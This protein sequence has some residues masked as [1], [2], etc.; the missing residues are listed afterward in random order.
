MT[1]R[2]KV[3]FLYLG[4]IAA[5]AL[6]TTEAYSQRGGGGRSG[7]HAAPSAP[8]PGNAG[9]AM[10]RPSGGAPKAHGNAGAP[11]I[12][13]PGGGAPNISKPN[14]TNPGGGAS[15]PNIGA[16]GGKP[17]GGFER[18][19]A[20]N[21]TPPKL[22]GDGPRGPG[23]TDPPKVG[24]ERP[25][26]PGKTDRPNVAARP[27]GGPSSSQ[28]NDF[29]GGGSQGVDRPDLG[30]QGRPNLGNDNFPKVGDR[31]N[32]STNINVGNVNVGNSVDYSKNQKAW[33]DNHHATGNQVRVNA[34]NRYAGAYNNGAY[35]RGAVGGYPYYGGWG[36]RGA[37]YGWRPVT[38]AS[39]G[40]FMGTAWVSAQPRYYA[41]GTGGNVYYENNIVYV[42]GQ[43]AGTPEE[44]AAQSTALVASAPAQ[45]TD[46]EWLP[47]G[48]FALTRE[49]VNDSQAMLELAVNKQGVVAGTYYNEATQVSR[50]L[51]GMLDKASQRAAIG[52]ADGK[53]T[54]VVLETGIQNLTQ[55]EAPALLH[56]GKERSGP[57][58][59]VRLQAP[60]EEQK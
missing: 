48:T 14:V 19:T 47:L 2:M 22:G 34:G 54:D 29:L 56:Q 1:Q 13:K 5:L 12:G 10:S 3:M 8:R 32:N 26:V 23:K 45:V 25:N 9:P 6:T 58:L 4:G 41:Y 35:R 28:L 21:H 51:K 44:Y 17:N 39:F 31:G 57:V 33:V 53:N 30:K 46:T 38:Y 24:V 36:N 59:L 49:G 40:T 15:R 52:F 11:N 7:G 42:D 16:G 27:G 55:D 18:P 50:S 20:G 43:A 37:Y 60:E